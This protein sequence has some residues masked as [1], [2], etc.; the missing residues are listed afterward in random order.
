VIVEDFF[1]TLLEMARVRQANT[2]QA[3][4]GKSLVPALR[5]PLLRN[6]FLKKQQPLRVC[7]QITWLPVERLCPFPNPNLL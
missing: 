3:V 6:A 7:S 4:T 2:V 5:N 1:P